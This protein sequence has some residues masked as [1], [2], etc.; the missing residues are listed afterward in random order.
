MSDRFR[1]DAALI[2][3]MPPDERAKWEGVTVMFRQS[4]GQVAEV[5]SSLEFPSGSPADAID[6][7]D[8]PPVERIRSGEDGL[9]GGRGARSP[10]VEGGV[11]ERASETRPPMLP[12][13]GD[14]VPGRN[15]PSL[16]ARMKVAQSPVYPVASDGNIWISPTSLASSGQALIPKEA[17]ASAEG[18]GWTLC[19][20]DE[21]DGLG[22]DIP[23]GSCVVRR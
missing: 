6:S 17:L 3:L 23:P 20:P 14:R 2:P 7:F 15:I 18:F 1:P 8:P 9:K 4:C 21:L 10:L 12:S 16:F 19:G 5:I 22:G 11:P 13:F